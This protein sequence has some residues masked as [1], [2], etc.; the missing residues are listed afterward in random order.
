MPRPLAVVCLAA[1]LGKRTKV[2]MPKVLLPLCGRTLAACALDATAALQPQATVVVLHHQME[3][4]QK[5]LAGRP[6]T[7]FVDQ[8]KPLGTG[9]AV[10]VALAALAGFDGDVLVVYGDCPLMTSATLLALRQA[11]KDAACSLL[12]ARPDD[13][14]GLGRILRDDAGR[15]L[16]IRE[17]KDCTAAELEL[18]EINAGFYCFDAKALRPLLEQLRPNNA[19]GEYY[20]TDVVAQLV[21]KGQAVPTL[22]AG[23]ADE[24]LGV[25]SLHDLALARLVL[26]GR[27]VEQHLAAGVIIT[28]PS[29]A[30]IDH[31]VQIGADTRILPCTVIST[32]CVI[33]RNCEVG[34]F[35][36]LRAGTVLEDGAEI[37]NFVEAKK[38]RIGARTKAKHLSYL[39]D[40]T[41]GQDANI[42]AGTITANYDGVH[43]HETWIGDR[44]FV[45]SGSV[46]VAPCQLGADAM[47]GAGAIVKRGSKVGEHEVWVGVPARFMKLREPRPAPPAKEQS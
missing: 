15:L 27:I 25:N 5:A 8:G 34:P 1:G 11:R 24:I 4:V 3:K 16:G 9:H 29:T 10:K 17:E 19:Q 43:K 37:G 38:C 45:G 40:A 47:T 39:G 2:S 42:G 28:D 33:G 26:Q 46:I 20:L 12:T 6:D 14:A 32:G 18:S 7:V 41:I 23:D 21:A 31:G 35:A 44:C 13:P 30:W 22:A 36:H